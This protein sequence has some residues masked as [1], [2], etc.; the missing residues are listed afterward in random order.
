MIISLKRNTGHRKAQV[1]SCRSCSVNTIGGVYRLLY[2]MTGT[3]F[4]ESARY[5]KGLSLLFA[6]RIYDIMVDGFRM[7]MM[8][9]TSMEAI[10]WVVAWTVNSF[11]SFLYQLCSLGKLSSGG[12]EECSARKFPPVIFWFVES[13]TWLARPLSSFVGSS[14]QEVLPPFRMLMDFP[15][16]DGDDALHATMCSIVKCTV[17]WC[18]HDQP[19]DTEKVFSFRDA[20]QLSAASMHAKNCW[21]N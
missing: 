5:V 6:S 1:P 10:R 19:D 4:L 9:V 13:T 12:F 7:G 21:I 15:S 20:Q 16:M 3:V 11:T 2:K 18:P 8:P 14:V 17:C